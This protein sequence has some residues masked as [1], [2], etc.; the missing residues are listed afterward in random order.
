M[1]SDPSDKKRV[2]LVGDRTNRV[3]L[4]D[5]G[6]NSNSLHERNSEDETPVTGPIA[7]RIPA[8]GGARPTI[9]VS[10]SLVGR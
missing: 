9:C 4:D 2:P 3:S 7:D 1:L 6:A 5:E 10:P 8:V